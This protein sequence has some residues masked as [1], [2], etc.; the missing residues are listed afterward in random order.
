MFLHALMLNLPPTTPH[1]TEH[2]LHLP[3]TTQHAAPAP[4][5]GSSLSANMCLVCGF[6]CGWRC[7]LCFRAPCVRSPSKKQLQP[8]SQILGA[9]APKFLCASKLC[10]GHAPHTSTAWQSHAKGCNHVAPLSHTIYP[11]VDDLANAYTNKSRHMRR[12]R[13]CTSE[14]QIAP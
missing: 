12:T 7:F 2:D 4:Q 9:Q 10:T 6:C 8:A 3:S 11:T 1:A 5:P 13:Y 14:L